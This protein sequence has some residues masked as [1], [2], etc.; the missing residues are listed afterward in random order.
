[1]TFSSGPPPDHRSP[2][3]RAL[4][5]WLA[6]LALL[7]A[8]AAAGPAQP[9]S[10][11]PAPARPAAAAAAGSPAAATAAENAAAAVPAPAAAPSEADCTF[12]DFKFAS[13]EALPELRLHY[14]TF[15]SPAR[16][17]AG[18]VRNAV[19]ILHG[20]TGSGRAFLA[21]TFAGQLFGRGQLLDAA[22][23]YLILP[24]GI[25]TGKSSR[26]SD[27][28]HMRFPKYTYDD[29]VRAQ[30]R[31]LTECLGV[32][33]LRLVIGTSMG[34]MHTWVW[35]YTYPDFMDALLP[36]ASLPVEIAGRNRM[37]RKM[38]VDSITS[39][40]EWKQG[41]YTTQPR[42]LVS[43][44][45]VLVF[46]VS[47]PLQWQ[48]EAPT[49]VQAEA[50]LARLIKRYSSTLDANDVIYQFEASRD[51]DPLPHLGEIRAPLYAINSAD[52]QINPPEL[53][54]LDQ[55]IHQVARGR[56]IL[57]P[58]TPQTRGH[59]THSLPAIW[60]KYLEELLAASEPAAAAGGGGE[61]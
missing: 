14:V 52:D 21:Q 22:T 57:L 60:S 26:P 42:G 5:V 6:G 30:H 40:P 27:G 61:R 51:Y 23:H 4:A 32:N 38:I 31:L 53:G 15:G 7:A 19:L 16:D 41:E 43:A 8:P 1:M 24:D 37:L 34:G 3:R 49:R 46:M 13:G 20:T 58:I 18:V 54:I 56:Y 2:S 10:A 45:H 39:D 50:L 59:G 48:K 28:L 33:H 55:A 35:G 47:S 25:G 17:A 29:M 9:P 11:G 12:H 36:L 44:I